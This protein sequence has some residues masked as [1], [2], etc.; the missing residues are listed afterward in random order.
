M[1]K[2]DRLI[3]KSFVLPLIIWTL[4]A[5]FIFNMQFLWKYIDDIIGKGLDLSIIFE[6]LFYQSLAMIPRAMVFGVLIAAVM[7]MG[8]LAEHYELV[9]M[10]S[11][12][13]SLFRIM[14]PLLFF[15]LFLSMISFVFSNLLIPV[16]ALKFK[17]TLHDIRKQKPALNFNEGQYNNDFKNVSIY[18][19]KKNKNGK[20]L[21][22]LK[23]YDHTVAGGYKGQTNA[24][25]GGLYF[26][27][28]TIHQ[29][30]KRKQQD[31]VLFV[32]TIINRS[33]LVVKLS[34]GTRYE[35]LEAKPERPTAYPFM[36][37]NFKT[38][39][40]LF[41]LSEFEFNE[42]NENLFKGHYSLLT[43]RQLI[44]AMDSLYHRR[45]QRYKVLKRNA[46]ALFQFRRE[47]FTPTDSTTLPPGRYYKQYTPNQLTGTLFIDSNFVNMGS[48]IPE[49]KK[50][51]I[52]QRAAGFCQN[53]KG[54]AHGL[55]QYLKTNKR[56]HVEHEN[57]IHQKFSFALACLLFLFIGAPMGAII[58]K[59]GFGWPILVAIIF[60]MLFFV[61]FLVGKN[62]A[63]NLEITCWIGSWLPNLV[64]LP[65][66]LFLSYKA[67]NDSRVIYFDKILALIRMVF[68]KIKP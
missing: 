30:I 61:L 1:K 53:I 65:F 38:Y 11:A 67:F 3:I 9:S 62:L 25:K 55:A 13:L 20:V 23:I 5:M 45:V 32:D 18:V 21:E 43:A 49:S 10:K 44:K 17:S 14:L 36:Q 48:C 39:T 28:D 26:S 29:Q 60:F 66:G 57:E 40:T 46:D 34:N 68:S 15:A 12:G 22:G 33:Y 24:E 59:G 64:L 8:N 56:V 42:T 19:D 52:Y 51:Y 31:T 4:V 47:G 37:M 16:T 58:R 2:I 35:E 63:T 41:D 54:Q 27:R 6:L 50:S 7:T